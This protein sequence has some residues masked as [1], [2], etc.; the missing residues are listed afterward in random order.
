MP[1]GQPHTGT[2]GTEKILQLP[3]GREEHFAPPALKARPMSDCASTLVLF[4]LY[5][6]HSPELN[7]FFSLCLLCELNSAKNNRA[8]E[9]KVLKT[10]NTNLCRYISHILGYFTLVKCY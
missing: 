3:H 1:T 2:T 4:T 7:H 9:R 8:W 5:P 6:H 10:D